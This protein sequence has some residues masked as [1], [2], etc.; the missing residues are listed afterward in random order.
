MEQQKFLSECAKS[1]P[2]VMAAVAYFRQAVQK[3]CKDVVHTRIK[4]LCKVLHVSDQDLK[5]NEYAKPDRPVPACLDDY[6]WIGWKATPSDN[7]DIYSLIYGSYPKSV[8]SVR[9]AAAIERSSG[10]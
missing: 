3:Q 2:E 10:K 9:R 8:I 4:E 5:L 6:H 7:L 1:Y